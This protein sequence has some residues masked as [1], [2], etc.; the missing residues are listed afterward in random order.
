MYST[1]V[2]GMFYTLRDIHT[3]ERT[4]RRIKVNKPGGLTSRLREFKMIYQ[5]S[6]PDIFN[7]LKLKRDTIA[8]IKKS[9]KSNYDELHQEDEHKKTREIL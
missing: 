4:L 6:K 2:Y 5:S 3:G 8:V 7:L 1:I 9:K